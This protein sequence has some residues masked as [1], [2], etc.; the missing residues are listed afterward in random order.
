[1]QNMI[2]GCMNVGKMVV[3][4]GGEAEEMVGCRSVVR[5]WY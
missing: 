4:G 5:A 3:N 1:M 2:H